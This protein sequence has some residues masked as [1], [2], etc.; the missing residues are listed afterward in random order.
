M[1]EE[2]VRRKLAVSDDVGDM[3]EA[4]GSRLVSALRESHSCW[5]E[6][7]ILYADSK[8]LASTSSAARNGKGG[9]GEGRNKREETKM[10]RPSIER[11]EQ[12]HHLSPGHLERR[13]AA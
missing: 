3:S 5:N 2:R 1:D 12:P 4:A 8:G 7:T 6:A 11:E 9:G 10:A 13:L